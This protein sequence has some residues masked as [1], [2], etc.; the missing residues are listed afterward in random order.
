MFILTNESPEQADINAATVLRIE[1]RLAN[2]SAPSHGY[3]K[4]DRRYFPCPVRRLH[5]VTD[6]IDWEG[7][8][9][10]VNRTDLDI[11]DLYQPLYVREVGNVLKEEP[12]EDLKV[13]LTFK[14]LQFAAPYS[15]HAF[16]Q[17][18]FNFYNRVLSGQEEMEPRWKRVMG[19]MDSVMGGAVGKPDLDGSVDP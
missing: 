5:E 11:I 17:E 1:T 9:T 4:P 8:L 19:I 14:T 12:I 3:G 13:F 7:L 16:E 18:H 10:S 6:G 15:G 2:A